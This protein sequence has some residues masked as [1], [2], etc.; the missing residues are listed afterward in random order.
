MS[1]INIII[2]REFR[3]RVAKKSFLI[4]TL[5]MPVLMLALMVTPAL[6]AMFSTPSERV[7]AVDDPTGI[8]YPALKGADMEYAKF[9]E[10]RGDADSVLRDT[11]YD[12][13]LAVSP[14]VVSNPANGVTLFLHDAASM[15]L[16][17]AIRNAVKQAVEEQR[18]KSYD[19]ENLAKIL[20][21]I[22]ADVN[23][24]TV[25]IDES[26]EGE[27]TSSMLSYGIGIFM[28]FILYM[29]LLM[30]GQMVMTSIIEE[31]NNRVLE[32]VVT[33]VKPM[34]LMLGKILGVGLVA[35][36]QV[37]IWGVLLCLISAFVVPAILPESVS[38]QVDMLNAG[39]L[40]A[41]AATTDIDLLQAISVLGS[42][43][44][45]AKLFGYVL[46][47]LVGGF[48]FYASIF[49]AIGSAVDNIQD[50]SQLQSFAVMPI[51]VGIII[52]MAAATDPNT[53]LAFWSSVIPFTSPMVMLI[54][55]PF[56][57]PG[58]EIA[59]SVVALYLS[60]VLMAWFAAK[61]YRVGIFMHGKKPSLKDLV[62][63]AR[64]N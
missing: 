4:T 57:I 20:D 19:I 58:W 2:G 54:R 3:E 13:V 41:A 12:A 31:K 53:P 37:V 18:L 29:F 40:D 22:Q 1:K 30:Y 36:V 28:S 62:R 51:I 7:I 55:I 60:F 48:L 50:A 5:L 39:T 11:G 10:V 23:L 25:R 16:E 38:Q 15:E 17:S 56:D 61:I 27:S 35:V 21:E 59:V 34:Q 43:W 46:L 24:R 47:F 63:W 49:A 14:D 26:G 42:V 52:G 32:L 6:I 9:V 64:Y 44:Y 33:S 45:I 8:I